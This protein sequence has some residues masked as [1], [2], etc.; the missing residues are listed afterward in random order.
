VGFRPE[1]LE[2]GADRG[3]RPVPAPFEAGQ[4]AAEAA[5]DGERNDGESPED[6]APPSPLAAIAARMND[7]GGVV[8]SGSLACGR[9][10]RP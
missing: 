7:R 2:V 4:V 6:P 1:G 9:A 8:G 10:R 5:S 3:G